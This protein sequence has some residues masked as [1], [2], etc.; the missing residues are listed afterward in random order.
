MKINRTLLYNVVGA[1]VFLALPLVLSPRPQHEAIFTMNIPMVRNLLA[2]LGMLGF[3]YINYY[4]LIPAFYFKRKYV[5]YLLLICLSFIVVI[6]LPSLLTGRVGMPPMNGTNDFEP[7]PPGP[8]GPFNSSFLNEVQHNIVLFVAVVLFSLLLRVQGR[9]LKIEI[10][11]QQDELVYLKAQMNPH[12]LFNTLNGIYALALREKAQLTAATMLKLS[13]IMRY[14]VT[15]SAHTFVQLEREV[16]YIND[17]IELQKIRLPKNTTLSYSF[18]GTTLGVEIAPH[19]LMPFIEN[20][21]KYGVSP[22]TD[23]RISILLQLEE[24]IITLNVEN[25]KVHLHNPVEA[26]GKGIENTKA[27]LQLLYPGKHT[28]KINE[29]DKNFKITL[30]INLL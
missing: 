19:N 8:R 6:Y 24:G 22:E 2:S 10:G 9:L 27:R 13:G 17:Y 12:F 21:F 16:S 11:K 4:G 20:A 1:S 25:D 7:K 18:V 5:L 29:D 15:E 28:L 23:S 3:F 26:S 30:I 14:V